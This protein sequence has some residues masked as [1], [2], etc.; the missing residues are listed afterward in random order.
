MESF[1]DDEM[2]ICTGEWARDAERVS[3]SVQPVS[4]PNL[5]NMISFNRTKIKRDWQKE[6]ARQCDILIAL[7]RLYK[8]EVSSHDPR[9]VLHANVASNRALGL[10]GVVARMG[11]SLETFLSLP[12]NGVLAGEYA[13]F[14]VPQLEA[15]F[16]AS[17]VRS[18]ALGCAELSVITDALAIGDAWGTLC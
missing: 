10:H 2:P 13:R 7:R 5:E 15:M 11:I 1:P 4:R 9:E 6:L 12:G 8:P 17:R 16:V 14:S 3:W 18:D